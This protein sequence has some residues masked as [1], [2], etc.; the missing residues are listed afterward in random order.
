MTQFD[1]KQIS[2]IKEA[3]KIIAF[4]LDGTLSVSKTAIDDEMSALLC[5]LLKK[6]KAAV[7]T[8]GT[9]NQ[10]KKQLLSHLVCNNNSLFKNLVILPTSGSSFYIYDKGQWR[11]VYNNEL[12]AEEKNS[13][14]EAFAKA[15][16]KI[17]YAQ[18]LKTYGQIIEDRKTQITFSALGQRTPVEKKE[19]WNAKKD[20]RQ[21]IRSALEQ[22][23]PKFEVRI[24]GLTS[25]DIT[26]KGI[27]KAY[28]IE[29]IIKQCNTTKNDIVFVGDAF[30]EGG[31]DFAVITTGVDTIAVNGPEDTKKL[32]RDIIS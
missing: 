9:F 4:D 20:R 2:V 24:G 3:K 10:L 29:Q 30:Y 23:L 6:K 13:I 15:F 12:T 7:V 21:E 28:A 32:I 1:K 11:S 25:I 26:K 17:N 14:M 5:A 19:Q 31:N 22:Y 16:K 8:G 27:D 18:P